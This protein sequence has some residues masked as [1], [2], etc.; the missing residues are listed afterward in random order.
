MSRTKTKRRKGKSKS[1]R[2]VREAAE[3]ISLQQADISPK[4][5]SS[6]ARMILSWAWKLIGGFGVILGIAVT[7]YPRISVKPSDSLDPNNALKTP[8]IITNDSFMPISNVRYSC[9]IKD[10]KTKDWPGVIGEPDY[11]SRLVSSNL[12]AARMG[13]GESDSAICPL[14]GFNLHSDIV[15]ADIAVVVQYSVPVLPINLEKIVPFTTLRDSQGR[16]R[17]IQKPI[18]K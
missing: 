15:S 12:V 18:G 7:F 13:I 4:P 5:G 10:V 16:L 3:S 6:K 8:F 17:W 14:A 9:A 11:S 1:P 2:G